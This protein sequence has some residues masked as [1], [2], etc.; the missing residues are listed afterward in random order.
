MQIWNQPVEEQQLAINDVSL[1]IIIHFPYIYSAGFLIGLKL[2]EPIDIISNFSNAFP[3][4]PFLHPTQILLININITVKLIHIP[5]L[6]I[7][8][9]TQHS[10]ES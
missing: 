10:A 6:P 5:R 4:G 1:Y 8:G 3:L 2:L 7:L 9:Y